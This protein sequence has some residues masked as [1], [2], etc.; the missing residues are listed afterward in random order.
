MYPNWFHSWWLR[1]CLEA[2]WGLCHYETYTVCSSA[3]QPSSFFP[4]S[5]F[6]H[7]RGKGME[8]FEWL[9]V[10]SNTRMWADFKESVAVLTRNVQWN[11]LFTCSICS[12]FLIFWYMIRGDFKSKCIFFTVIGCLWWSLKVSVLKCVQTWT[13]TLNVLYKSCTLFKC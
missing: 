11:D 6:C 2:Q 9:M 7:F 12:D 10:H 1:R 5:T 3:K 4:R 8:F 13:K